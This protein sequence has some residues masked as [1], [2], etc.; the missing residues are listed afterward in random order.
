MPTITIGSVRG[1]LIA[2]YT[3]RSMYLPAPT[4]SLR[5]KIKMP[6]KTGNIQEPKF[7]PIIMYNLEILLR[8]I[9]FINV[10]LSDTLEKYL[11][12]ITNKY[13]KQLNK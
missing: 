4:N 3:I 1:F 13:V 9:I 8:V 5:K 11:T 12:V 6:V 2:L 10:Y 7:F